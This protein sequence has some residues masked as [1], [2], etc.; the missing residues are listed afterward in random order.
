MHPLFVTGSSVV[1]APAKGKD[2]LLDSLRNQRGGLQRN[3][4][5][6]A[7]INGYTGMVTGLDSIKLPV[8]LSEYDC[9]NNRLAEMALLQDGFILQVAALKKRVESRR[10]GLFLGTSTSGTLSSEEAYREERI[11]S[12]FPQSYNYTKTHDL[13]SLVDYVKKRLDVRGPAFTISTACSSSAKVFCEAER[14]ISAGLC[15]AA[16]VGGVDSLCYNTLFGFNSLQ[17][18]S[19]ERCRP[20]DA[21][22]KGISIGEAGGFMILEKQ[23]HSGVEAVL[24]G[25]G[26]SSDAHHI[27]TPHPEGMGAVIAI[28]Q[29]LQKAGLSSSDIGYI[30]LHGTATP[31]ND[32][33][34]A[35]AVAGLFTQRTICSSTKGWTGHTLG[36]AGIVE[37]VI[38]CISLEHGLIP[39]T[40]NTRALDRRLDVN[41][42]IDTQDLE[43]NHAVSNSFGFGGSNCSLIF[44]SA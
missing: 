12:R 29:A 14:F 37:A 16:V 36:A 28:K 38:S 10:I 34:E 18:I 7:E 9:R 44:A 13:N 35:V 19:E 8:A 26:E 3:K 30:N 25:Y 33:S 41:L 6:Y 39:G 15:D 21:E 5:G 23:A 4:F 31:S 27:S 20:F 17:L 24:E 40:L 22:R 32:K 2:A 43:Y 1:C 11:S 42:A